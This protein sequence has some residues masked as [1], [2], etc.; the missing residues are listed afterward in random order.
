VAP[1]ETRR[2]WNDLDTSSH[3]APT[4]KAPWTTVFFTR[5][6]S[7]APT[8]PP[9]KALVPPALTNIQMSHSHGPGT[10]SQSRHFILLILQS[11]TPI[12][13]VGSPCLQVQSQVAMCGRVFMSGCEYS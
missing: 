9:Q 6:K 5:G 2:A 10:S 7:T 11:L 12:A 4:D 8:T 3:L 13:C 1:G